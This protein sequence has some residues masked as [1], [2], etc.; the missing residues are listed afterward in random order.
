ML[1]LWMSDPESP[2]DRVV[3]D[4]GKSLIDRNHGEDQI[5]YRHPSD[6]R[7]ESAV[8]VDETNVLETTLPLLC[9]LH[10]RDALPAILFCYDRLKC[11]E[12]GQAVLAQLVAGESRWK[13]KSSWWKKHISDWEQWKTEQEKMAGKKAPK[14]V[15]KKRNKDE[16]EDDGAGSKAD[17]MQDAAETEAS[18][19]ATFDPNSP[20][21]G[22]HF[23]AKHR[24]V[25]SELDGYFYLLK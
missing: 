3:N 11:E 6:T 21:D 15:V 4:L 19:F 18:P 24:I 8:E 5:S 20:I 9:K 23:A 10:D 13:E 12:I 14:K 2:F 16:D 17:R 1:R 7:T 25:S 22:F